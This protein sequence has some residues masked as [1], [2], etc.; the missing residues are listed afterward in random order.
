ML[1]HV[2]ITCIQKELLVRK[3]TKLI[4]AMLVL[5]TL[6]FIVC[7]AGTASAKSV[8]ATQPSAVPASQ[9][10]NVSLS[11]QQATQQVLRL[12]GTTNPKAVQPHV[13]YR[14]QII[15]FKGVAGGICI[16]VYRECV[17]PVCVPYAVDLNLNQVLVDRLASTGAAGAGV[18]AGIIGIIV[19]ALGP[20]VGV[21]GGV[22]GF[23]AI[24]LDNFA[25]G[26]CG[27]QGVGI[28]IGF[29]AGYYYHC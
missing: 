25:K 19:P 11:I 24:S 7:G 26:T 18:L 17:G 14:C 22:L 5:P 13:N 3:I 12:S 8:N 4:C 2:I 28:Y 16:V 27:S 10:I 6:L 29:P 15:N 9:H 20:Y 1:P 23:V 21:I